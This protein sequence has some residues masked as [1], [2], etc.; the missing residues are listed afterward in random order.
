VI[1]SAAAF[2]RLPGGV[3][4]ALEAELVAVERQELVEVGRRDRDVMDAHDHAA[5]APINAWL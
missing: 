1:A 4:D 3:E 5:S 2:A